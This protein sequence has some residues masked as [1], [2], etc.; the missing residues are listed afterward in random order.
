[1]LWKKAFQLVCKRSGGFA[2]IGKSTEAFH[3]VKDI[4]GFARNEA[5]YVICFTCVD[6]KM[7]GY[8]G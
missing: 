6:D 1:M 4:T 3:Q 5:F 7:Y 2:N 8:Y